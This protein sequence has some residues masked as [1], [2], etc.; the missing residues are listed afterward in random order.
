MHDYLQGPWPALPVPLPAISIN[1]FGNF[2]PGYRQKTEDIQHCTAH[3]NRSIRAFLAD[4]QGAPAGTK[5]AVEALLAGAGL[6]GRGCLKVI[7]IV[8]VLM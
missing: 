3:S 8:D 4:S 1:R 7:P 5:A 2:A 6:A